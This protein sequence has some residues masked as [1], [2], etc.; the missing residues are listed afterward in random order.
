MRRDICAPRVDHV[1]TMLK[2]DPND[3]ILSE[4]GTNWGEALSDLI[5]LISL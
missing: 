3:I 5:S 1:N 4:I 2:R